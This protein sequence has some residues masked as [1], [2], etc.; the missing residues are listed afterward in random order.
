MTNRTTPRPAAPPHDAP[1][2]AGMTGLRLRPGTTVLHRDRGELQYGTDP[3]WAVLLTGLDEREEAWLHE[4]AVRHHAAVEASAARHRVDPGRRDQLV[5][6]LVAAGYL[7]PP[8]AGAGT[9]VATAGGAADVVALAAL[10][11]DA[12]GLATLARRARARVGVVGLGRT[13]AATALLLATA[14][15]G[16]VVPLDPLPVQTCDVAPGGLR[17]EHVGA[18]RDEAV[19]RLLGDRAATP[20][21]DGPAPDVVVVVEHLVPDPVR[22]R[23]LVGDGVPHLSVVVREADVV[24]GPFVHPGRTACLRCQD[25]HRGDADRS[26]PAVAAQLRGLGPATRPEETTL[27]A[28]AAALAA[29]QVLAAVDG[30]RPSVAGAVAEVALP[31]LLPRTRDLL[32]HP[33]CGCVRLPSAPGSARTTAPVLG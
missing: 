9:V 19:R 11:P 21:A 33:A 22:V 28:V 14:G 10:R 23:R 29:A 25:L 16:T 13:G 6:T 24:V 15:V 1:P 4:L 31:D 27:A 32:P 2:A 12:A 5:S 18:P 3:R 20:E 7:V 30:H 17:D 8:A 26:W